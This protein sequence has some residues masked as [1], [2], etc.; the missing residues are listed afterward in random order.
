MELN[1]AQVGHLLKLDEN[2]VREWARNGKLPHVYSQGRYRY[3]RQAILEWALS[4]NHPLDLPNPEPQTDR[5]LLSLD[6][7]FRQ[8]ISIMM[9]PAPILPKRCERLWIGWICRLGMTKT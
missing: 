2:I 3:N 7:V 4:H 5:S 1:S 9:F 6:D 8:S